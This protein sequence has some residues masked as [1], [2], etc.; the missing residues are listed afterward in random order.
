VSMTQDNMCRSCGDEMGEF[1]GGFIDIEHAEQCEGCAR[2]E[3]NDRA[4]MRRPE[5]AT[6]LLIVV[7]D[8]G[9]D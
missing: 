6:V 9:G 2:E 8:A 5:Q 4:R 3:E 7:V 1:G